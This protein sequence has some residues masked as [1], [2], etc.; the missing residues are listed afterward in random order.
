MKKAD[1]IKEL[2]YWQDKYRDG[3]NEYV[4]EVFRRIKVNLGLED[5]DDS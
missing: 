5:N 3:G 4:T 1:V 2:N